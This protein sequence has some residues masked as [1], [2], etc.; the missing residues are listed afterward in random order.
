M[1]DIDE[2]YNDITKDSALFVGKFWLL[3][4]AQQMNEVR[5]A[6]INAMNFMG[7]AILV[8]LNELKNFYIQIE[9]KTGLKWSKDKENFKEL[10]YNKSTLKYE[11]V[12]I[13]VERKEL[14]EKW[15]DKI[16]KLWEI[17]NQIAENSENK[18]I[19]LE[20]DKKIIKELMHC[21]LGLFHEV[22]KK[23]LIMPPEKEHYKTLA[24][25]DWMDREPTK[26]LYED[27]E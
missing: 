27:Y 15:F 1:K 14:F 5:K 8:W 18:K 2:I 23:H 16:E 24:R 9:F 10:K 11:E 6:A 21:Q 7:H 3:M 20:K 17:N 12:T 22:E 4:I 26:N 25:R 13:S 19:K